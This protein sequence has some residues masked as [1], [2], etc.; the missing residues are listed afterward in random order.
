MKTVELADPTFNKTGSIDLILGSE[1][2]EDIYLDG[3]FEEPNG[4][5]FRNT[6]FGWVA[7]GKHPQSYSPSFTTSLCID[8]T[9]DLK[10][11]WELEL[12]PAE[13]FTQKEM[14]VK[15]ISRILPK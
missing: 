13:K 14:I 10:K 3:K 9:F 11:F 2:I 8:E 6:I 1:I 7:S 4:L 15:N 12:P 5:K